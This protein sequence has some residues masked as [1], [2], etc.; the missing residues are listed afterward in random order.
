MSEAPSWLTEENIST[1]TTTDNPAAKEKKASKKDKKNPPPP[2][3]AYTPPT[4]NNN[5]DVE[6]QQPAASKNTPNV[7]DT[8]FVIDKATLD[9]MRKWHIGLRVAYMC[10]AIL[11]ATGAVLSFQG[12]DDVGL[13]F[14]AMY[15]LFFSVMICCF[16]FALDVVSKVI[17]INFGFM[18]T[19]SGR[20]IFIVLVGFMSY[21]LGLVSQV[22]MGVLFAALC[23]H[24]FIMMRF[25]RFEE[26]LR[27]KHYYEGKKLHKE[28]VKAAKTAAWNE[29]KNSA[30][31]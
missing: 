24:I 23:L 1:P 4:S 17:A 3:P 21:W 18:Y 31:A 8:E 29:A 20:I 26:Y 22:A 7:E 10:A 27:K 14:F 5:N 28:A 15:V 25:P 13:A 30:R 2:P 9:E 6:A 19:L 12:Q 16:E 11:L